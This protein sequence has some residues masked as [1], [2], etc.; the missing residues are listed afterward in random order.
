MAIAMTGN[1]RKGDTIKTGTIRD[2]LT[3]FETEEFGAAQQFGYT[4]HLATATKL[5]L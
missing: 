5:M 4:K 1:G 3:G 2:D